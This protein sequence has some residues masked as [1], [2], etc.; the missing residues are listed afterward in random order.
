MQRPEDPMSVGLKY[1]A[2]VGSTLLIF[3]NFVACGAQMY[4][5]SMRGDHD[6]QRSH[7]DAHNPKSNRYGLHASH[8]WV[9]LPIRFKVGSKMD[10]GQING[11]RNAMT[12]WESAVGKKLFEFGGVHQNVE[13]DSFPDLFSSLTDRVNGNYLDHDWLKTKKDDGI[14]A[15]TIW[16]NS[17]GDDES[18]ET[19]DIR[20]NLQ[21]YVLGDAL[22]MRKKDTREVV[23]MESL[24]LHELGHLLGLTH[25][26][27]D[28]DS[29]SI[30]N[31]VLYVGEGLINRRLSV[32]DLERV[33][34][35]YGCDGSACDV[36][37]TVQKISRLNTQEEQPEDEDVGE[38]TTRTN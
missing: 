36:E 31:P 3:T 13:G 12:S 30:M 6:T 23:D 11:L 35:I 19:A 24:A 5:V 22:E 38:E 15:T 37:K 7:P 34:R 29:Q 16:Q 21:H 8:G 4:Q 27:A 28:V 18:I 10:R 26:E 25:I 1:I 2:L 9:Q 33:Q 17:A 32:G 20:Y 14:L